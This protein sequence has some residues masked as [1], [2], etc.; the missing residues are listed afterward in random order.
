MKILLIVAILF[1]FSIQAGAVTILEFG[2]YG[3]PFT[4]RS[5]KVMDDLKAEYGTSINIEFKHFPLSFQVEGKPA[6]LAAICAEKQG[7]FKA[8]HALLF[9][10]QTNLSSE[11]YYEL[12]TILNLDLVKYRTCLNSKE[13]MVKLTTDMKLGTSMQVSGTP[14]FFLFTNNKIVKISGSYPLSH[15]KK[16]IDLLLK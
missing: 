16:H 4:K 15:F 6:A 7:A 3:C 8:M 10:N 11:L 1:S 2:G 14:S 9:E 5:E 13:A 12:A